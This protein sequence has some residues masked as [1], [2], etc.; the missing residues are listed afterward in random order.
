MAR[1][2]HE[3][4]EPGNEDAGVTSEASYALG[5]YEQRVG[6]RL[7]GWIESKVVGRIWNKD[8]T[9]WSPEEVPEIT[10]RLGWLLLPETM[11]PE[12]DDI[13]AFAAWVQSEGL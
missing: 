5:D 4:K 2:R 11:R 3:G 1:Y 9:V 7:A 12:T 6:S 13:N 10:D 8:F